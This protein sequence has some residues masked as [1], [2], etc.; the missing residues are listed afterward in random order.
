[1]KKQ[2]YPIIGIVLILWG[3]RCVTGTVSLCAVTINGG[4][5]EKYLGDIVTGAEM[6]PFPG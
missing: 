5:W 6:S 3:I 2:L 1:M 4:V